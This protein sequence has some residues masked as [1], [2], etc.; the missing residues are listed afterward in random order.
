MSLPG[1]PEGIL[2]AGM[3]RSGFLDPS[4]RQDLIALVRDGKAETRPQSKIR[5]CVPCPTVRQ[6]QY[7]RRLVFDFFGPHHGG[8]DGAIRPAM[9]GPG[10]GFGRVF[11]IDGQAY[12]AS[13]SGYYN[14]IRPDNAADW[15]L[16]VQFANFVR[17][18][19]YAKHPD[20]PQG[21]VRI[22]FKQK[23]LG[24]IVAI[25]AV[26]VLEWFTDIDHHADSVKLAWM[27]GILLAFAAAM[28]LLAIADRV[29]RADEGKEH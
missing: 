9:D 29:G 27:V 3:I 1:R 17:P 4:V 8:L 13:I 24:S 5:Q 19:D 18:I 14:A 22:G 28:L 15:Q 6:L 25:A 2:V 21:L 26:N 23:L 16:R 10:G 7:G 12:N 11:K 20:W